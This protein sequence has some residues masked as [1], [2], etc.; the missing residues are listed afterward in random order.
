MESGLL[1]LNAPPALEE[2]LIDWLLEQPHVQGFT[3]MQ[4]YG[5]GSMATAMSV[6][7]QVLGRQKRLQFMVYGEMRGLQTMLRDLR[8]AYPEAG[9][10]YALSPVVSAGSVGREPGE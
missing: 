5:H 2:T 7:E 1:T 4:V 3:S 10:H 9:L 8:R 6:G